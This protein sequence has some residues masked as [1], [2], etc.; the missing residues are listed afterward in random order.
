MTENSISKAVK[1]GSVKM[2]G[3]LAFTLVAP[4]NYN[5]ILF[6]SPVDLDIVAKIHYALFWGLTDFPAMMLISGSCIL[7][8]NAHFYFSWEWMV[9]LFY[10]WFFVSCRHEMFLLRNKWLMSLPFKI[11][12]Y[13]Y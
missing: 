9:V 11:M 7:I 12:L 13:V 6:V 4:Y 1:F 8:S 2:Y 5:V 10:V 3:M